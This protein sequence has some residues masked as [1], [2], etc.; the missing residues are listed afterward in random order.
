MFIQRMTLSLLRATALVSALAIV[1]CSDDPT[2]PGVGGGNGSFNATVTGGVSATFSGAAVQGEAE[3]ETSQPGWI[4][5]LGSANLSGNSV[6][7]ACFCSRPADGTYQL[8]DLNTAGDLLPGEWAA[9]LTLGDGT[10]PTFLGLSTGGSVT[11]T[12]SS[13]DLVVG[14][15][16]YPA[17]GIDLANPG[18]PVLA[19]VVGD[20]SAVG[21]TVDLPE[22]P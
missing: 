6:L 21:G 22:I 9:L 5:V 2:D 10:T 20:F 1:A 7:I 12:S 17:S 14:T 16:D 18:A 3:F 15:Y 8:I 4:A 13:A 19:T 11:I